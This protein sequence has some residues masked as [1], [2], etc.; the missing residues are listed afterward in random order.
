MKR[1]LRVRIAIGAT[2]ALL[3]V[4]TACGGGTSDEVDKDA[5]VDDVLSI[6]Y[7]GETPDRDCVRSALDD[8][9]ADDLAALRAAADG[10]GESEPAGDPPQID[11]IT[12]AC[13]GTEAPVDEVTVDG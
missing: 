5:L 4:A 2:S 7:A 9:S 1:R 12:T 8:L 6:Y 10:D 11:V 3:R 13:I